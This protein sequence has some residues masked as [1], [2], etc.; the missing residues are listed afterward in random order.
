[1]PQRGMFSIRPRTRRAFG[2]RLHKA[3]AEIGQVVEPQVLAV[4]GRHVSHVQVEVPQTVGRYVYNA[5]Q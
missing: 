4:G 3:F 5:S 1:M 2:E